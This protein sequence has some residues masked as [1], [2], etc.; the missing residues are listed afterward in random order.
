MLSTY[1]VHQIIAT[2]KPTPHSSCTSPTLMPPMLVSHSISP[3]VASCIP[4]LGSTDTCHSAIIACVSDTLPVHAKGV[5]CAHAT[6]ACKCPLACKGNP[7]CLSCPPHPTPFCP[8]PFDTTLQPPSHPMTGW[9]TTGL[10]ETLPVL[11]INPSII[12]SA[13]IRC[14]CLSSI[15]RHTGSREIP[16]LCSL[17]ISPARY[18]VHRPT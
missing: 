16:H 6:H 9:N 18:S 11:P 1:L 3:F 17:W 4:L 13:L 7:L 15:Y 10:S 2:P 5:Q 8:N 14:W 12:T